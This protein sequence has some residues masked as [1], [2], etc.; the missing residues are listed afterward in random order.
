MVM[1]IL[2]SIAFY[3]YHRTEASADKES[4]IFAPGGNRSGTAGTADKADIVVA[5]G[6]FW[7]VESD[8]EK[9]AAVSEVVSGY[10]GGKTENPVYDNYA[11]GGHREV[12]KVIY[13]PSQITLY[14]L[15]YYFMKHI[16]PT[17]GRGS[18]KDRGV[19][20][21]PAIY[22]ETER[23]KEIAERVL[24]DIRERGV[25][26]ED[27]QVPILPQETFYKAE[28]YHQEYYK[29]NSLRYNLYRKASGRD[30]FIKEHWG[31]D[32]D[33]VPA[34]PEQPQPGNRKWKDYEKPNRAKLK[35]T[36]TEM[37]YKVT[38][39]DGTEPPFKN[40]YWDEKR[41]GIYVDIVSGE[42]LFSSKNKYKSGTGWPSFTKPLAPENIAYREDR[43]LLTVRTEVRSRHGDSHL[44][45]VFDDGP[46]TQKAA[47]G[48]APTGKRYCL[49]SAALRFIPVDNLEEE[50]Y[51]EYA[52][53]FE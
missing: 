44:G 12:A 14:G 25:F 40:E 18:F 49:N 7:C 8:L 6:C 16:D 37:Q 45:H 28:D 17:D 34:D 4:S 9:L 5:G 50:G 10:S 15:L 46:T 21:S 43:K 20:Y 23:E 31:E 35:E 24:A 26:E 47:G 53:L 41:E 27:L 39:R 2:A 42:P 52:D 38:Q 19:E 11:Q 3:T 32:A 36:L 33:T 22:Y 48:A 13:D 1:A 30:G 29:N 51:G